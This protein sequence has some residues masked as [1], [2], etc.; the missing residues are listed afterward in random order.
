MR[1]RWRLTLYGVGI[2][3]VAM[4]LFGVVLLQLARAGGPED[5]ARALGVAADEFAAQAENTEPA[6]LMAASPPFSIDV[7]ESAEVYVAVYDTDGNALYSTGEYQGV[8]P[9]LST[10]LIDGAMAGDTDATTIQLG[11]DTAVRVQLRPWTGADGTR[12]VVIA[13][14][15]TAFVEQQLTGLRVV[16]WV[17]VIITLIAATVAAWLVAGRALRPLRRLADTTDEIGR[18]GDLGRR[19][20]ATRARDEL[21]TLTTSFNDMLER[22]QQSQERIEQSL[23]SQRRFVGDASHELRTPLTTI[24]SNAGFLRD[25][26]NADPG[27]RN[28]AIRDIAAEA[29]RMSRLVS[30]LLVLAAADAGRPA[31]MVRVDLKSVLAE[32]AARTTR[33]EGS[34]EFLVTDPVFVVGSEDALQ[35]LVWILLDNA[36]AHGGS[37]VVVELRPVTEHVELIITD[38]GEGFPATDL[39]RVFERFYRGDSA[40]SPRGAG[41]GL[42]IAKEVA[43]AHNGS[44]TAANAPAGGARVVVTLP[45]AP[46]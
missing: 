41:L 32:V 43:T 39:D 28:D 1:I 42:A 10:S 25:H 7:A 16:V 18:T 30:D 15:S 3:A 11:T 8:P 31:D 13:G 24:R 44:I 36:S 29:D 22:L 26:P 12:G 38:S 27:D 19:L 45:L 4:V 6:E 17:A 9:L 20:P 21:G 23:E 40:R 35:Q 37:P 2:V 5:Q 33:L 14:Q 46:G 34:F